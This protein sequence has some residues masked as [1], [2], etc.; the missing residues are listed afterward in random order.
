MIHPTANVSIWLRRMSRYPDAREIEALEY[1]VENFVWGKLQRTDAE[2][3]HPYGIYGSEN[4]HLNRTTEWGTTDP[5]TIKHLKKR[6]GDVAGTG[7]GKE[8]MWRTFDYTTYIMLYHN[9][10][11]I[12]KQNPEIVSYLDADGYLERAF[13]TAQAYFQV[14]YAIYMPGP[15]LWS[16]K[17]YQRLG[18]QAGQFSRESTLV[19]LIEALEEEGRQADADYLRGEWEKKVKYFIYDDPHPYKSEMHFDRTAF[20]STHAV[21]RYALE[22]DSEPDE[23]LWYDKNLQKWYSHPHVDRESAVEFMERQLA[24][25]ISLRGWLETAYYSLGSARSGRGTHLGYMSQMAGWSI[26]DYAC[27][28]PRIPPSICVWDTPRSSALGLW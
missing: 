24:T 18:L 10:Y 19:D 7:L 6:Y 14:P 26:L 23:N 1:F 28:M 27:T 22:N 3:P 25:N 21:S 15:P 13:G 11:L 4:W 12:A 20:E 5:S 8:R 9:L 17:G 16:H 2:Q